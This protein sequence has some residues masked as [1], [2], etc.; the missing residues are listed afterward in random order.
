MD[1][2]FVTITTFLAVIV[3]LVSLIFFEKSNSTEEIRSVIETQ[4]YC[5]EKKIESLEKEI[6]LLKQDIYILENGYEGN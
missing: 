6:R 5:T 2:W 4:N 3:V 1:K